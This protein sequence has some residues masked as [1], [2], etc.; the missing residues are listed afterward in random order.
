MIKGLFI[1]L[2]L[3]YFALGSEQQPADGVSP[4]VGECQEHACVKP[5]E[6]QVKLRRVRSEQNW[7]RVLGLNFI[8]ATTLSAKWGLADSPNLCQGRSSGLATTNVP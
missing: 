6:Q 1:I 5:E 8:S 3:S 7:T 2:F 4:G